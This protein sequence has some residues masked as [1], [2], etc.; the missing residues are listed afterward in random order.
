MRILSSCHALS[1][2]ARRGAKAYV[3]TAVGLALVGYKTTDGNYPYLQGINGT[4]LFGMEVDPYLVNNDIVVGN[5]RNYIWNTNTAIRIDRENKMTD[6]H[7]VYGGYGIFDG[8]PKTGAFSY[9]QFSN[10]ISA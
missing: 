7:V 6:R 1:E 9:A 4:A 10:A 8:A 2:K 3:S 5:A